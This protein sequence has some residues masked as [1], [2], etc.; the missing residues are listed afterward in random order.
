VLEN[1]LE[2]PRVLFAVFSAHASEHVCLEE[3]GVDPVDQAALSR[4]FQDSA[5]A[6]DVQAV[7]PEIDELEVVVNVNDTQSVGLRQVEDPHVELLLD[8]D[9]D[10]LEQPQHQMLNSDAESADD[11]DDNSYDSPRLRGG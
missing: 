10:V 9:F 4:T 2:H 3:V 8:D 5:V 11:N 7:S 6:D 1:V